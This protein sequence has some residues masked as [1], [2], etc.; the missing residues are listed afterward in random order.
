MA[1]PQ[2]IA[3]AFYTNP[4]QP[5]VAVA[6]NTR[7]QLPLTPAAGSPDHFVTPR[8]DGLLLHCSDPMEALDWRADLIVTPGKSTLP[9]GVLT[10]WDVGAPTGVIVASTAVVL[11]AGASRVT[12]PVFG[13]TGQAFYTNGAGLFVTAT[14][15]VTVALVGLYVRRA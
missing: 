2:W 9:V 15:A 1:V 11:P 7:T 8:W 13:P 14:S 6:A 12:W 3:D 10:E 5:A 4:A